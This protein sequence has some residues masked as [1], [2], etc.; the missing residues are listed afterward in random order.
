MGWVLI[1][2]NYK[3]QISIETVKVFFFYFVNKLQQKLVV[4]IAF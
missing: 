2:E 3:N 1:F 4:K